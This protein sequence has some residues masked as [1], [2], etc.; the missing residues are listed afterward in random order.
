MVLSPETGSLR[1]FVSR[2]ERIVSGS[3]PS[4]VL[5]ERGTGAKGSVKL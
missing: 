5:N 4:S 1:G 2:A 3:V